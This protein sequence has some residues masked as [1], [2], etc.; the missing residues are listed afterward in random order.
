MQ[1]SMFDQVADHGL[2]KTQL[3][4]PDAEVWYYPRWL[5]AEQAT[6]FKA[7]LIATLPWRQ[8]DIT[9]FGKTM[10]IPRLQSWHGDPDCVYAYSG[11]QLTPAAW[12]ASL[13][14]LRVR[15][16]EATGRRFNSVLANWYR[17]GQDSMSLHADDEP[18]LGIR[19]VIASVTL[20]EERPFIFRHK[21]TKARFTLRLAHGSLLVMAGD[22]QTNYLHGMAKTRK[23]VAD[24]I[25]LTFR[26]LLR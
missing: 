4:L 12:T 21:K 5:A 22:T 25:N 13:S 6:S 16:E 15:C 26:Y 20:G 8:D 2:Q 18:E 24:R 11:M 14:A 9:L 17:D 23:P 7:D 3:P 10:K 1:L 19:P